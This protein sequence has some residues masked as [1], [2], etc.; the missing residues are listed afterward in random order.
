MNALAR[1]ADVSLARTRVIHSDVSDDS[2]HVHLRVLLGKKVRFNHL[3][4][5]VGN[6]GRSLRLISTHRGKKNPDGLSNYR[7]TARKSA[8]K[9]QRK[10]FKTS[11]LLK[12]AR[13]IFRK[14]IK[15]CRCQKLSRMSMFKSLPCLYRVYFCCLS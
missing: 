3:K 13:Q 15:T 10:P 2:D 6:T 11:F 12:F 4:Q 14:K 5:I 8:N 7:G 9:T 1:H